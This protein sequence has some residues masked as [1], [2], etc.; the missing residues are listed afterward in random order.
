MKKTMITVLIFF[1]ALWF[2]FPQTVRADLEWKI[3]RNLDLKTPPLDIASSMDGKW[4][5]ILTPGEILLFSAQEGRVVDRIPVD[6]EFDRIT[7]LPRS[8]MVTIASSTQKTAQI[9]M[10]D[11]IY[12]IDLSGLH[13]YK[14]PQNA[15]VTLVVFDDYQ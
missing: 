2:S 15:S 11:V 13:F 14:G 10:F 6:K 8:D 7:S 12:R 5:F 4:L 1:S 3:V 9:I